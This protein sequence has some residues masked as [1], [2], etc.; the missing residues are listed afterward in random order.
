MYL[1]WLKCAFRLFLTR[2]VC[3]CVWHYSI[4]LR[5]FPS[6]R[7]VLSA[8]LEIGH[9]RFFF[10]F[11]PLLVALLPLAHTWTHTPL[12]M[13]EA[14]SKMW[15]PSREKPTCCD[16]ESNL[17]MCDNLRWPRGCHFSRIIPSSGPPTGCFDCDLFGRKW[18]LSSEWEPSM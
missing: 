12:P 3:L 8:Y 14:Y 9:T 13:W 2:C 18:W 17:N 10:F 4:Y 16:M 7:A 1:I 5:T 11:L 6:N 15:Y